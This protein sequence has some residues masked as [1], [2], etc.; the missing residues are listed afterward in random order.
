[1]TRL[2]WVKRVRIVRPRRATLNQD[3]IFLVKSV[4]D[5]TCALPAEA[6]S[7]FGQS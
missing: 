1:M 5:E 6:G 4:N 3:V 2:H 7:F